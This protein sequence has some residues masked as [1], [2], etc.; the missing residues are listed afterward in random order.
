MEI[1]DFIRDYIYDADE[2]LKA[3]VTFFLNLVIQYEANA[4][5]RCREI[6]EVPNQDRCE[7][8]E[9]TDIFTHEAWQ[10]DF[11]ETTISR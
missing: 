7:E 6:P 5:G 1:E 2:G 3:L 11:A 8:R 4:A 10:T 9:Q